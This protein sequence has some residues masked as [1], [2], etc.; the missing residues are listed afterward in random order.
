MAL[1]KYPIFLKQVGGIIGCGRCFTCRLNKARKI[2]FRIM[3]EA[4]LHEKTLWTTLTYNDDYLP[5]LY[6]NSDTGQVF[7]SESSTFSTLRPDDLSLFIKRV[8]KALPPRSFRFLAAGEYGESTMRPHYHLCVFGHGQEILPLLQRHWSCPVTKAPYGLV[9]RI[10]HGP[11]TKQNA[12][13]TAKYTIKKLTQSGDPRLEGRYP[14]F[15]S[16]S[17]GIGLE[18]A[19]RFADALDNESGRHHILAT[20][21]I[22][23][24]V[25][26]DGQWWPLDRYLREKILD[27]LGIKEE[28]LAIGRQKFKKQ[29]QA[30]SIRAEL[31]PKFKASASI[32]PY[33]FEKQYTQENAQRVLN[34]E[35]RVKLRERG[36]TL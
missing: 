10:H 15:Q 31:N 36:T 22:P 32:S 17:K 35:K 26:F 1:C 34:T 12:R 14:E 16:S 3:M 11:I 30:L 18:F 28:A 27:H 23:R 2:T 33:I 25:R 24:R 5:K 7:E 21:D 13:Y 4:A 29:M 20:G 6:V 9:D 19:K 8:R